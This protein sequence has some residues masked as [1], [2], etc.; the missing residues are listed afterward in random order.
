VEGPVAVCVMSL[1]LVDCRHQILARI[2]IWLHEPETG[3]LAIE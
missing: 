2:R 1:D 3:T